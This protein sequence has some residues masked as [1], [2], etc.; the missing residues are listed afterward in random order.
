[1]AW[2]GAPPKT[3]PGCQR[4]TP[5]ASTPRHSRWTCGTGPPWLSWDKKWPRDAMGDSSNSRH[6]ESLELWKLFPPN[7]DLVISGWDMLGQGKLEAW[8]PGSCPRHSWDAMGSS[9]EIARIF[10]SWMV[11]LLPVVP[12]FPLKH[13][14]W[15]PHEGGKTC[16]FHVTP[17][18]RAGSMFSIWLSDY[19]VF[20]NPI[21]ITSCG[22]CG[23]KRIA[24]ARF[25][26]LAPS[27][28]KFN[29]YKNMHQS[30]VPSFSSM[31]FPAMN[32]HLFRPREI[33]SSQSWS[34]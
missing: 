27:L 5:A 31:I 20:Q 33:P 16:L 32:L 28:L 18:L 30:K 2:K 14:T 1:M 7:L 22:G 23:F 25:G 4:R 34:W 11:A 9:V 26:N 19:E 15:K 12:G 8:Q 29:M 10:Q 6:L 3:T 21:I 13:E 24:L 17:Q